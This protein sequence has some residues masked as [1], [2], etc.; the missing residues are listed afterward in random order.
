MYTIINKTQKKNFKVVGDFPADT[1][2]T[3]L[4]N[5]DNI[6]VI[7]TYSNTIKVPVYDIM[8]DT[9]EWNWVDFEYSP[10]IFK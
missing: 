9:H 7:S 10:D 8:S 4:C 1:L 2:E 5:G 6:I 3:M